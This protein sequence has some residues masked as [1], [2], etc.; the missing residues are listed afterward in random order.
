MELCN[1]FNGFF[2][3]ISSGSECSL[4]EASDFIDEQLKD[5]SDGV[6]SFKFSFT[7]ATE[8]DELFKTIP[9][10]SAPGIC[11]ISTKVLKSSSKKLKTILAYL[12]NY[13]FLTSKIPSEWKTAVVTPLFK[14]KGSNEDL[15]NYR[16]ISIL[17]PVAKLFEKLVHNQILDYFNSKNL[18]S[19]DQ[20]GFR[21]NHSCESALHEI[22]SEINKIRSKRLIGLLLFID[23]KKAFDTVDSELLLIKLKKYGFEN[24]ALSLIRDYF[25]NRLQF[26]KIDDCISNPMESSLGVP[27]G[28]VLGP[29]LFLI[30]IND[31]VT[32]LSDFMVKLFADDTTILQADNNLENLI[33]NFNESIK[34]LTTWCKFNRIDINW[35]KTK[36]MFV[37]NKRN[38]NLPKFVTIDQNT[39]EVVDNF[40][41][42]GITIDNK[43]TFLK[44][45]SELRTSINKR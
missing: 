32:F 30:F 36:I 6:S 5:K 9:S 10:S 20:H 33:I 22:V 44:Y 16:G 15:N 2:T 19:N 40:K 12:F 27:Q 29:L 1:V 25:H 35:K 4:T 7:T 3:S 42:L 26:V 13:S 34:K 37:S 43:L 14:K 24:S 31:I 21:A 45:V 8:I 17:P 11:G 23:F 28:S 41:L 39:V 18:I 38:L